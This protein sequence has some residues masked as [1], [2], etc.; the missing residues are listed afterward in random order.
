MGISPSFRR[1]KTLEEMLTPHP[2]DSELDA[3]TRRTS[4]PADLIEIDGHL[5]DCA[6]CRS[7]IGERMDVNRSI[8]WLQA[9]VGSHLRQDHLSEETIV[10][11]AGG[12]VIPEAA[13]HLRTCSSCRREVDDLRKFAAKKRAP[14]ANRNFRIWAVAAAILIA[15]LG[16]LFW[17]WT[18]R[19]GHPELAEGL[20]DAGGSLPPD[21]AA[22]VE[23]SQR[24]GQLEIGGVAASL[25]RKQEVLL[26]RAPHENR[27]ALNHPIAESMLSGCPQF[28]WQ[29]FAGASTYRVEVYDEAFR[30]AGE[31]PDLT[32]TTW[33]PAE[34]LPAGHVYSWIVIARAGSDE[35][36]EPVPPSPEAK[37]AVLPPEEVE[38]LSDVRRRFPNAH[39]LL[40]AL[41]ARAGVLEEARAE[42]KIL[43]SANPGST[44]VP[45]LEKSLDAA[46]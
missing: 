17:I 22:I 38:R 45:R 21:Y 33:I 36:R 20:R 29:A 43:Q 2:T 1:P 15:V 3:F 4:S 31:S 23:Q 16:P 13:E 26:G 41:Y 32:A 5:S 10:A 34:P 37:F 42:L 24:S 18:Q 6:Q 11:L 9:E 39:L 12:E 7:R 28:S 30:K 8:A 40:A 46:P 44:L 25:G 19:S 27:F 35:V 14:A